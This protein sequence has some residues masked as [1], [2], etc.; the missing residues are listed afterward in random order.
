MQVV[1][2]ECISSGFVSSP[3]F[4]SG[5]L[6]PT[7]AWRRNIPE[8]IPRFFHEK[9]CPSGGVTSEHTSHEEGG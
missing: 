8:T 2:N 3:L 9:D 5:P 7:L 6:R 1:V 4:A